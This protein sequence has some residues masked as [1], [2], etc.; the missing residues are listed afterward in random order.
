MSLLEFNFLARE[1]ENEQF[2]GR[3]TCS[4]PNTPLLQTIRMH[5]LSLFVR[6]ELGAWHDIY[7]TTATE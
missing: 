2:S 3:S 1:Q 6:I 5:L 4:E 7:N